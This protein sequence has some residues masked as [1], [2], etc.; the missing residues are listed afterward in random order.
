VFRTTSKFEMIELIFAE[1]NEHL[2]IIRELFLEYAKS[3]GFSLC[4]QDFDKELAG[5]PGDYAPPDGL[6]ILAMDDTI[7]CGCVALRKLDEGICEMKRLYVK[8]SGRGKGLGKQ[9]VQTVID[10]AKKIGYTKMRLDTVPKMKEAITLY[11][12]IGF[13]EIEPYRENPIEG[14]LYLE[15]D[16]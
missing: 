2:S 3:L 12:S 5:L 13:Y 7:A 16:L 14:D 11:R 1:S 6:L 10:E 9:L 8:P 15:L 4:F